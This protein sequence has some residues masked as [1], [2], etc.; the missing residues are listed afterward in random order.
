MAANPLADLMGAAV[1]NT[2]TIDIDMGAVAD[3]PLAGVGDDAVPPKALA[4]S[5]TQ[6]TGAV[7]RRKHTRNS[8]RVEVDIGV[9][10]ATSAG[11]GQDSFQDNL[12]GGMSLHKE[13]GRPKPKEEPKPLPDEVFEDEKEITLEIGSSRANTRD[14]FDDE[15]DAEFD[16]AA[17]A[18][19]S[20]AAKPAPAPP[21]NPIA[22][23]A[24]M[25]QSE[26]DRLALQQA[27][28]VAAAQAKAAR[29]AERVTK[30]VEAAESAA[31]A[32][33][34]RAA[35][36]AAALR[37]I[38]EL[39]GGGGE[40]LS[41]PPAEPET[42]MKTAIEQA[43]EVFAASKS[44]FGVIAEDDEEEE[45]AEED[46]EEAFAA[47]TQAVDAGNGGGEASGGG[48]HAST[49]PSPP[50]PPAAHAGPTREERLMAQFEEATAAV[51]A[52]KAAKG[53]RNAPD[54]NPDDDRK[55]KISY[56]E[57]SEAL[58]ASLTSEA[59]DGIVREDWGGASAL[60][61]AVPLLRPRFKT[62]EL[63][64]QRDNLLALARTP[65][66]RSPIH[67]R[68]LMSCYRAVAKDETL[69]PR[70]G[71]AWE[72]IGFQGDDP[73]TDLRGAG[74]LA[75]V[76]VL[77]MGARRPKLL[78]ELFALSAG[79]SAFPLMTVSVNFTQTAMIALR[80]GAL[81]RAANKALSLYDLFHNLHAACFCYMLVQWRRR[82][83]GIADFGF[84]KKEIEALALRKPA[85][86]LAHL[87]KYE[88][89]PNKA[90]ADAR[91]AMGVST[92]KRDF[93][94]FG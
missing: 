27:A 59:R 68:V 61:R 15:F 78:R 47:A 71:P 51:E 42:A 3:D 19:A 74:M 80:A 44:N 8:G 72:G 48:G 36:R 49:E 86:L 7:A 30:E 1:H 12:L 45:D 13:R 84:L 52:S 89:A 83:L 67:E 57:A 63:R 62:A 65:M 41:A 32:A 56:A 73:S 79:G 94:S 10:V 82:G 60:V 75:L 14:E 50:P 29:E 11:S 90:D 46:A 31:N 26:K 53:A 20:V 35:E 17:S 24:V 69:P 92:D 55:A 39:A 70:F 5:K 76:Q 33:R 81:T 54:A 37:K 64:A 87:R 18:L 66:D 21:P 88:A 6:N 85:K 91:R 28:E 93:A 2:E 16:G 34:E 9:T 23:P 40:A 4:P 38:S 77:H 22:P 58:F 25:Q 43:D